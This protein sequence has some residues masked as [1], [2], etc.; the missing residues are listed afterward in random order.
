MKFGIITQS[1]LKV[2]SFMMIQVLI[3]DNFKF[4]F[5]FQIGKSKGYVFV[6]FYLDEVVKVVVDIMDNYLVFERIVKCKL[7]FFE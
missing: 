1:Q 3:I 5:F 2:L 4:F 7:K 6:E